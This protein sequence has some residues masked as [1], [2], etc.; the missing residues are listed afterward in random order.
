MTPFKIL[1]YRAGREAG[2]KVS[3]RYILKNV[4]WLRGWYDVQDDYNAEE[5]KAKW[6]R[7][8]TDE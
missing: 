5:A 3:P 6:R 7:G 8:S 4:D 1:D 2:I